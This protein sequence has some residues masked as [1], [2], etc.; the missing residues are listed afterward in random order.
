MEEITADARGLGSTAGI[1]QSGDMSGPS[2]IGNQPSLRQTVRCITVFSSR[3]WNR[4]VAIREAP[5][6]PSGTDILWWGLVSGYPAI[7][8]RF[9][10]QH[11]LRFRP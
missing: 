9:E 11:M 2:F 7:C 10:T 1:E 5:Q 8:L 3:Y 4:P 6:A